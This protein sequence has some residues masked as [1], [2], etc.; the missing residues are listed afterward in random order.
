M[1]K[2]LFCGIIWVIGKLLLYSH[3]SNSLMWT[4]QQVIILMG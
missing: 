2:I 1:N 3:K 4:G